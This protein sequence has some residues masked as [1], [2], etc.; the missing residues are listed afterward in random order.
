MHFRFA[1]FIGLFNQ[2]VA[3]YRPRGEIGPV[4]CSL[5]I[6]VRDYGQ[7]IEAAEKEQTGRNEAEAREE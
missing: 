3:H 7:N 5:G 1:G 2:Q 6:V 4:Q